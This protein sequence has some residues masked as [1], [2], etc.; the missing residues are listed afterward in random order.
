MKSSPVYGTNI[1]DAGKRWFFD[2]WEQWSGIFRPGNWVDF[3]LIDITGE[4]SPYKG[5]CEFSAG[6]LGFH[7]RITYVYDNAA[8]REA[9]RMAEEMLGTTPEP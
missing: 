7:L 2:F 4:W 3:T 5:S 8:D 6:L 1:E 9:L